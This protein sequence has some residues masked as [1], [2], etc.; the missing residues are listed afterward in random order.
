M[1]GGETRKSM[2]NIKFEQ[3]KIEKMPELT[4]DQIKC[5]YVGKPNRCMC[6]CSGNYTYTKANQEVGT[7][8]RGY[9][10]SDDEVNDKRVERILG[11]F[12]KN[13]SQGVEVQIG[14][15]DE[16]IFNIVLG[17]TQYTLYTI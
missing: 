15:D 5:A 8:T 11:R 10:V 1:K 14:L 2:L 3:F 9:E 7:K 16:Y 17:K 13:A 6:G 12:V 4:V